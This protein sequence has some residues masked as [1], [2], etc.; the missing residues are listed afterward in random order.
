MSCL[1]EVLDVTGTGF[2]RRLTSIRS[3][4]MA[5]SAVFPHNA[6]AAAFS[7]MTGEDSKRSGV[8]VRDLLVGRRGCGELESLA[9]PSA[10]SDAS[11]SFESLSSGCSLFR[12]VGEGRRGVLPRRGRLG[13][14]VLG[15]L[16]GGS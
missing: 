15:G 5:V 2:K 4:T 7:S 8:S 6:F 10:S 3:S 1:T 13:L 11:P 9:V 14:P 16:A 12:L